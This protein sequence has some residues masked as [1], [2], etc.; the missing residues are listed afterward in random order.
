MYSYASQV[1]LDTTKDRYLRIAEH[2]CSNNL[3]NLDKHSENN[4]NFLCM[5]QLMAAP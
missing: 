3:T 1:H 5:P 2:I 4:Q